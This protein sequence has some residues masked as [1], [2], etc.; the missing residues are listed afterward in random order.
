[1]MPTTSNATKTPSGE[2]LAVR[3][4]CW[5]GWASGNEDW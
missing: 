2:T 3:W 4:G 1:M 5:P